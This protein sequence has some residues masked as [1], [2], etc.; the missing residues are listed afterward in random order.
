[1]LNLRRCLLFSV[2]TLVTVITP[3][4]RTISIVKHVPHEED[5][6][7]NLVVRKAYNLIPGLKRMRAK[8][9][10]VGK[11]FVSAVVTGLSSE[12]IGTGMMASSLVSL[13]NWFLS[14]LE[15]LIPIEVVEWLLGRHLVQQDV[16][17]VEMIARNFMQIY[18][19]WTRL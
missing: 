1:M 2:V 8:S 13:V 16:M 12:M 6:Y 10:A 19:A 7:G 14:S 11:D 4:V 5:S 18:N 17:N 3:M 9:P 15:H